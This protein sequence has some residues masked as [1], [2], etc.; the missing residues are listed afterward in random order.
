M[1][2]RYEVISEWKTEER[3]EENGRERT[4]DVTWQ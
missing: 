3:A 1:D 4:R 2:M